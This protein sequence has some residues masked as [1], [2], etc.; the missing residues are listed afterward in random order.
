MRLNLS[1][2]VQVLAITTSHQILYKYSRVYSIF[3]H[4]L[5]W[6]L[7]KFM[8][9]QWGT[10]FNRC[11]WFCPRIFNSQTLSFGQLFFF[12][13]V[14]ITYYVLDYN[15]NR[16]INMCCY[17][18]L[19]ILISIQIHLSYTAEYYVNSSPP[20]CLPWQKIYTVTFQRSWIRDVSADDNCL[21]VDIIKV[22][23]WSSKSSSPLI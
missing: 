19:S 10:D 4:M 18:L 9:N 7:D 15:S 20:I 6:L 11:F 14:V 23:M 2:L 5:S 22:N 13:P 12:L 8:L 16:G 17:R 21:Q 3:S 1:C